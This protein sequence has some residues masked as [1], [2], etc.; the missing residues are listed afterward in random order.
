MWVTTLPGSGSVKDSQRSDLLS[1]NVSIK[2]TRRP[3]EIGS[4]APDEMD[5]TTS[6]TCRKV[7][8]DFEAGGF[9]GS[10]ARSQ[11]PCLGVLPSGCGVI[12]LFIK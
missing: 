2:T 9:K 3:F 1:D 8:K 7:L 5:T 10:R 4:Y 11:F 12:P 6:A